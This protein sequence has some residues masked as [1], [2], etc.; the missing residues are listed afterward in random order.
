MLSLTLLLEH[1]Y[2]SVAV[3]MGWNAAFLFHYFS[4]SCPW[5]D[6]L[7][8]YK[9]LFPIAIGN[10]VVKILCSIQCETTLVKKG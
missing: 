10:D 5:A 1:L 7:G 9:T 3:L 8:I 4:S 2:R 6:W